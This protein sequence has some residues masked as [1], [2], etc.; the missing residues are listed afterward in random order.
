MT[1]TAASDHDQIVAQMTGA[2]VTPVSPFSGSDRLRADGRPLPALRD[3]LRVIANSR[4]GLTCAV[5]LI[6]PILVLWT[7]AS[8]GSWWA[9][10]IAFPV[11]ATLQLRMYIL[12]HEAAHRLLFSNRRLNDVIGIS[13]MGWLPVGTGNHAYR[14]V[15]TAH[16]KDEFGPKEPDFLLYSLYPIT[17]RS[18]ARKLRRDATGVSGWRIIRPRLKG[19]VTSGRRLAGAR[20]VGMQAVVFAGFAI[21][22]VPWLFLFLWLLPYLTWYQV[23]N[24]LRSIGEHAGMTRGADRRVTTHIVRPT[25]ASRI[26]IAPLYVGYHLP[27]HVDSGIPMRNL[28]KLQQILIEDGYV[29]DG[30]MWQSYTALWRSAASGG[31]R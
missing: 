11:M 22:G 1:V 18:F 21:A 15:H 20:L 27:H 6:A 7:T 28:P 29:P 16:H 9:I 2:M 24:R 8:V 30:L 10:V 3:E 19:L 5:A 17:R 4:N 23:I 13:I 14:R 12:H 26:F 25:L 31:A